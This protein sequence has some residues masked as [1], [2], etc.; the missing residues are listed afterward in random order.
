MINPQEFLDELNGFIDF[1]TGVPDSLLKDFCACLSDSKSGEEHIIA[2]NEGNSVGL[3]AGH[4][5]G[6]GKPALVYM[7]NS[8]LGNTV[9]PLLSLT[10]GDVYRIPVLMLIGW[11]GEPGKKDE[12]QHVKQGKV[13][14]DLLDCMGI[15]YAIMDGESDIQALLKEARTRLDQELPFAI[16]VKKGSFDS[17]KLKE[18][19]AD[20]SDLSREDAIELILD[21]SEDSDVFVSTTGKISRELFELREKKG[22]G[23]DKDFLIVGSMGHTS[24]IAAGV[25]LSRKDKTVYCLDGDGSALMHMGSL[26]VN[27]SVSPGNMVHVVLNNGAHDTVGG[28]PTVASGLNMDRIAAECGYKRSCSCSTADGLKKALKDCAASGELSLIEVRVKKGARKELGRPT[29][30]PI[31][32]KKAFMAALD[33]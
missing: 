20:I 12:P 31:Q 16:V 18:K 32:C 27:G 14:L 11:R 26:A 3:A 6:S 28:Q 5:L 25:A 13:T 2:A 10:D 19:P 17:Y 8:G 33:Q 24:Q 7:Q 21:H 23:H 29:V 4:F 15:D 1:Y 30:T 22:L 9:N